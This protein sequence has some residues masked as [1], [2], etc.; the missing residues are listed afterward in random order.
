[1]KSLYLRWFVSAVSM[2]GIQE[3]QNDQQSVQNV[4]LPI[5]T[6]KNNRI[7]K[8]TVALGLPVSKASH[9]LKKRLFF[10][11]LKQLNLDICY[12]CNNKILSAEELSVDHKIE[13]RYDKPEL[14]WDLNNIA[15]SH[16]KCNKPR[17][18]KGILQPL[19]RKQC[20]SNESWCSGCKT[21]RSNLFF[22][23]NVRG[24]ADGLHYNCKQ[25]DK[26]RK[27]KWRNKNGGVA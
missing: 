25:C 12:R 13:W 21:C 15:Y 4:N 7:F 19:Y 6:K 8:E 11:F 5:G 1:M 23:R 24:K 16:R 17:S 2:N 27:D 26:I 3:N 9:T 18:R 14:F 22:S 10:N 20:P